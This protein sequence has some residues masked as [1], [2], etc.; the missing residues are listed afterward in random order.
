VFM[1]LASFSV[2]S[3]SSE[4][5]AMRSFFWSLFNS[6]GTNLTAICRMLRSQ[7]LISWRLRSTTPE[8]EDY[9]LDVVNETPGI[10]TQSLSCTWV[11]LIWLRE[12]QLYPYHLQCVQ[13]L[14]LQV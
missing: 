13:A 12:Q 2:C 4:Q 9:I 1:K 5:T 10:N 6:L 14:S 3:L 8:V 11:S 7:D